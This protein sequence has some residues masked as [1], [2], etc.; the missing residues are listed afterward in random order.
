MIAPNENSPIETKEE[1]GHSYNMFLYLKR[2]ELKLSRLAF[3][4]ELRISFFRY[5]L[6]E[7]GYFKPNKKEVA[8]ISEN[9]GIDFQP[10]VEGRN[11]YP[12]ELPEKDRNPLTRFFYHVMGALGVRITLAVLFVGSAAATITGII[13]NNYVAD[14][15]VEYYDSSYVDYTERLSQTSGVSLSLID[16]FRRPEISKSVPNEY[17]YTII[18]TYNWQ[19]MNPVNYRAY[20]WNDKFNLSFALSSYNADNRPIYT[21]AA[22]CYDSNRSYSG[23]VEYDENGKQV[24]SFLVKSD[25]VDNPAYRVERL[26]IAEKASQY[27]SENDF[28]QIWLSIINEQLDL[29]FTSFYQ[30][31][32]RPYLEGDRR[33]SETARVFALLLVFGTAAT[34]AFAFALFYAMVYGEKHTRKHFIHSDALL[35]YEAYRGTMK[36]DIRFSPF[37]PETFF[38]I[39][40]IALVAIGA[41]RIII[42]VGS[43]LLPGFYSVENAQTLPNILLGIYFLGMFLL[44][45]MDFDLFLDDRRVLRNIVLY[46]IAFVLLYLIEA[47]FMDSFANSGSLT[48]TTISSILIPN[49]FMSATCYFL[50]MFFLFF[51]PKHITKK[52]QLVVFRYCAIL[53]IA[54]IIISFII[55]HGDYFFGWRM[56]P[57][58]QYWFS[59]ERLPYSILCVSYLVGLYFLRRFFKK[60][61]GEEGAKRYF[62]G[63]R[64]LFLKNAMACSIVLA[65]WAI[66]LIFAN[67]KGL[68]RLGIG[69]NTSLIVLVPFL[70][71]YHPHKGPRNLVFDWFIL[72][73]YGIAISYVYI[74]LGIA[75]IV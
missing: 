63:N 65:V 57:W 49:N 74:M 48:F 15:R 13:G 66:E 10:Y 29:E 21:A 31:C 39:L 14:H 55:G 71:F 18:G 68:N 51:T 24:L 73:L 60:K 7:A 72:A 45:F 4:K 23:L 1:I 35:G 16:E 69:V 42:L 75:F 62:M 33:Y 36:K 12:E 46:F 43:Y 20:F 41:L 17:T 52:W 6:I 47:T 56:S 53:P 54:Y 67:D 26:D 8:R 3:A 2:R 61:Y 19:K 30:D 40:G 5:R 38:E 58:L 9:L 59:V 27:L 37:L 50:L 64:F 44:Y 28:E 70:M 11:S 32:H 34:A 25:E 22:T